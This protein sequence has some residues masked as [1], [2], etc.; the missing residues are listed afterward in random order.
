MAEQENDLISGSESPVAHTYAASVPSL[1]S[2]PAPSK[3]FHY[4]NPH[5]PGVYAI[6]DCP[7]CGVG[8]MRKEWNV[9]L[10]VC[11][12]L[13]CFICTPFVLFCICCA[14]KYVCDTC[15]YTY[16]PL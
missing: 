5:P 9:G 13:L 10:I 4:Q 8:M 14:N 3:I 1:R 12:V 2:L 6:G 7:H 16:S 15:Q 11:L